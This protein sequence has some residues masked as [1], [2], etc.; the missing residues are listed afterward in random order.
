MSVNQEKYLKTLLPH[1]RAFVIGALTVALSSHKD[2]QLAY[3]EAVSNSGGDWVFDDPAS[4][5]AMQEAGLK[6]ATVSLLKELSAL[7]VSE[8]PDPKLQIVVPGTRVTLFMRGEEDLYDVVSR[9]I[10]GLP[11]D[12]AVFASVSG[13]S[14]LGQA[15]IGKST[16]ESMTWSN[17]VG[18][19][20]NATVV[21]LDQVAQ[22]NFYNSIGL[23]QM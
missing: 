12:P 14:S 20:F 2:A 23:R 11:H 17:D 21:G 9:R 4:Q 8:I 1:E 5:V 6:G 13:E 22:I 10:P 16:G 7:E 19:S 18:R 3:G 15:I